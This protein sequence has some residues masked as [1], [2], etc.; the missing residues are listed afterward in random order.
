MDRPKSRRVAAQGERAGFLSCPD[1]LASAGQAVVELALVLPLLLLFLVGIGDWARLYTTGISV[2]AAAREA[3]MYGGF[4]STYWGYGN[5]SGAVSRMETRVCSA[6]SNLP[7][8]AGQ[9]PSGPS[10]DITCTN[11]T[12]VLATGWTL[13]AIHTQDDAVNAG[14][15]VRPAGVSDCSQPPATTV[16]QVHIELHYAFHM[17]LGPV[18]I[19]GLYSFPGTLDVYRDVTAPVNDFPQAP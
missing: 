17:L 9:T 13:S 1:R 6:A 15:L 16:C 14:I 19:P 4:S 3:A 18:T 8:Y 12:M 5:V 7:D 11:P 2:E 10:T